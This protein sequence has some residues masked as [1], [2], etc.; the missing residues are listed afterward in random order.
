MPQGRQR[1]LLLISETR[2][3]GSHFAKLDDVVNLIGD[4]K[5][6]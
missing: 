3:H 5:P 1:A 2:D 4:S 6:A